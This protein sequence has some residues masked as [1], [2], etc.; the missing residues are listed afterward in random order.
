MEIQDGE[1]EKP[2]SVLACIYPTTLPKFN[3][4]ISAHYRFASSP[5]GWASIDWKARRKRAREKKLCSRLSPVAPFSPT[6]RA[7][8]VLQHQHRQSRRL[9]EQLASDSHREQRQA[10]TVSASLL[11]A[12]A[13]WNKKAAGWNR[14][15]APSHG[16]DRCGQWVGR[17]VGDKGA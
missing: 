17:S 12:P 4:I 5:P 13:G 9:Q 15:A 10:L 2:S 8:I 3:P 7:P 1:H 16:F 6:L 11:A 14:K